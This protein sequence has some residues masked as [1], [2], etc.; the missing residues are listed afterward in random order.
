[1]YPKL[2]I[3]QI[4]G[5]L[6]IKLIVQQSVH[7]VIRIDLPP[8]AFKGEIGQYAAPPTLLKHSDSYHFPA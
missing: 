4:I 7:R 1:M 3:Y 2:F 6:I 8:N 5:Y